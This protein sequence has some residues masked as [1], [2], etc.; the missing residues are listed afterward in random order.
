MNNNVDNVLYNDTMDS[1]LFNLCNQY[2]VFNRYFKTAALI[3]SF[4]ATLRKCNT[5]EPAL[6]GHSFLQWKMAV[7][8][9]WPSKP[10]FDFWSLLP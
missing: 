8:H 6:D 2:T 9:E 5:V 4:R 7:N 3:K 1:I 10:R